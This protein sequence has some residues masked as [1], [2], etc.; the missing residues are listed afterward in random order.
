MII[1]VLAAAVSAHCVTADI[2]CA[3]L[4]AKM[5]KDN[6]DKLVFI[7]I[8]PHIAA[9]LVDVDPRMRPFLRKD[10]S[11]VAEL[12]RALYGCVESAQ[13]WFKEIT[14]C[15]S[16]MGFRPNNCDP[17]IMN[18]EADGAMITIVIYVDDLLLVRSN[19]I[20]CSYRLQMIRM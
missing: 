8:N 7:R 14:G 1:L 6:P 2:G 13:L 10:G 19:P 4:N 9:M 12:D 3:Y 20:E 5:P 11:I 15:L 17:C 16:A 18:L